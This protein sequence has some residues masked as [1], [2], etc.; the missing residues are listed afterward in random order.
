ME[1]V[2]A[3]A[4]FAAVFA[5][6][7]AGTGALA[8]ALRRRAILDHPNPRSS[9]AVPTPRGGG[10]AVLAVLAPAW[11]LVALTASERPESI[12]TVLAC[13]LILAAVS[14]LD[15]LRGLSPL[16]RIAVQLAAV[17]AGVTALPA[18]ALVFQGLLPVAADRVAA[19]I[20]WVWFVNLFNFMDGIDGMTGSEAASIG[21]GLFAVA[22]VTGAGGLAPEVGL[23]ALTMA[24]AALGFL[25]WNWEPAKLFIGDV[26]SIPLGYLLGWLLL[27]AAASGQWA[28]ALILPLYYL[29]DATITLVRRLLRGERIWQAHTRHLYQQAVRR[30]LSH[31]RVV[32]AVIW[33]NLALV[34][35]AVA[36]SL[37]RPTPPVAA[38]VLV[39]AGLLLYLARAG[40]S[41][42]ARRS[43]SGPEGEQ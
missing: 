3:V 24:A 21:F 10:I 19:G 28:A 17:V 5:L 1:W 39:V 18:G 33:A 2:V 12:F 42:A 36:A 37:W 41:N 4:A 40:R 32:R 43:G 27:V 11:A 7:L 31:A 22:A 6:A 20:L 34:A 8:R 38:A 29:A 9:H 16:S 25:W 14:W 13:G 23:L 30:G 35:L 15:D 26:G